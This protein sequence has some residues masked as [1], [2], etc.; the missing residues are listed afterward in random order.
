MPEEPGQQNTI[1][2]QFDTDDAYQH[3]QPQQQQQYTHQPLSQHQDNSNIRS[4]H[5]S[6]QLQSHITPDILAAKCMG[7]PYLNSNH[8]NITPLIR[9]II[10]GI[11]PFGFYSE[12]QYNNKARKTNFTFRVYVFIYNNI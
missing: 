3:N 8:T 2:P 10:Y 5:F 11:Y 6:T 1:Q 4:Q 9:Y 12:R 7:K